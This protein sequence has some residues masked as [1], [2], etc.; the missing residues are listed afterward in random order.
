MAPCAATTLAW[1]LCALSLTL[2]VLGLVL[3]ALILSQPNTHI[4][5]TWLDNTLNAVF[6]ST[7]GA[8]VASR[9]PENKPTHLTGDRKYASDPCNRYPRSLAAA[10]HRAPARS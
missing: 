9:R 7:V 8:L 10:D 1:G 3:L 4:Y 6:Y 2:T 5:D